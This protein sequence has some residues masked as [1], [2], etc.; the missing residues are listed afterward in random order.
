VGFMVN[1]HKTESVELYTLLDG[2]NRRVPK[3]L[4]R[5]FEGAMLYEASIRDL[6]KVVHT[7]LS[8]ELHD[9]GCELDREKLRRQTKDL[10]R[11][12]EHAMPYVRCRCREKPC[13][14]CDGKK[15]LTK[16]QWIESGQ[17]D[18]GEPELAYLEPSTPSV[19]R[20]HYQVRGRRFTATW[21]PVEIGKLLSSH[22]ETPQTS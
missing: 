3:S 1:G 9:W 19:P 13:P 17:L 14:V 22:T 8:F 18:P 10:A 6:Y 5:A 15:W 2:L 12:I 11:T 16:P 21:S 7:V 4:R 20:S